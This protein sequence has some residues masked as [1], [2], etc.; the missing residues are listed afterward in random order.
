[1][2]YPTQNDIFHNDVSQSLTDVIHG[3]SMPYSGS[4]INFTGFS[5]FDFLSSFDCNSIN[6]EITYLHNDETLLNK[7]R[8]YKY[9]TGSQR[10]RQCHQSNTKSFVQQNKNRNKE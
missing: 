2:N 5:L 10:D 7:G 8:L 9:Y 4:N 6:G 3:G 1:M